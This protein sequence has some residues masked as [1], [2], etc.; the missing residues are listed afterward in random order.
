MNSTIALELS[1]V[2]ISGPKGADGLQDVTR[3]RCGLVQALASTAQ[4][5]SGFELADHFW[6]NDSK[7]YRQ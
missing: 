6:E 2:P 1:I 5:H 7:E 3:A 4:T